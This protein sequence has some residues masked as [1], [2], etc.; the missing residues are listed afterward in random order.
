MHLRHLCRSPVWFGDGT[1]SVAP[2]HFYQLYTLHGIVKGQLLPLAFCI[3]TRKTRIMYREMFS[4]ICEQAEKR[5]ILVSE[6]QFRVDFE[7][8]CIK[9]F[10]DVYPE[11]NVECCFF[12]LTQAHWR[13]IG[14][15]GLRMRYV[16]DENFAIS[17]R[18]F[19]ALAFV[20][21]DAVF[22][23]FAELC[24]AIPEAA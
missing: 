20:P 23:V 11:A 22:A 9:A 14:D 8:P 16:E 2:Q 12:H 6:S 24:E 18:M 19:T 17:L 13:K 1:F 21:Q 5:D 15:L 7:D 3:L 4:S 10:Q